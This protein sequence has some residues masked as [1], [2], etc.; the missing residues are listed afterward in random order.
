[1]QEIK[2]K[3]VPRFLNDESFCIDVQIILLKLREK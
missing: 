2:E 1:M 3:F